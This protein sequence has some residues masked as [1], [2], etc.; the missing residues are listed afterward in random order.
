MARTSV[1]STARS[2]PAYPSARRILLVRLGAIGDVV[3]ALVLANALKRAWPDSQIGW[4]VGPRA[5]PVL[6]G[7]PSISRIHEI[8]VKSL[9]SIRGAVAEIREQRYTMAIDLQR[10]FKSGLLSFLSGAERR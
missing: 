2:T 1:T 5:R 9:R 3:N 10:L 6:E 4:A 7:H 8:D